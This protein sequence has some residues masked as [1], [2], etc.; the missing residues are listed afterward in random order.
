MKTGL[1]GTILAATAVVLLLGAGLLLHENLR[2]QEQK[3]RAD[4]RFEIFLRD[5]ATSDELRD[6][7]NQVESLTG[8]ESSDYRDKSEAYAQMQGTLGSQLLPAGGFNPFPNSLI[9]TFATKYAVFQTFQEAETN[10]KTTR[11]VEGIR[12]PKSAILTQESTYVFISKTSKLL[13]LLVAAALFLVVWIGIRRMALTQRE[14]HRIL[15]LLGAGWKQIAL[16]LLGKGLLVGLASA[17]GGIL[18]LYLCWHLSLK[19]SLQLAFISGNGIVLVAGW[20]LV[21]GILSGIVTTRSHP[22]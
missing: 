4:L 9:V 2:K 1:I 13:L 3:F 21:S 10:L 7:T 5:D 8:Y 18:L 14:E 6:L 20:S 19:L 15:V 17:F 22:R 11:C 16:P 12:Y